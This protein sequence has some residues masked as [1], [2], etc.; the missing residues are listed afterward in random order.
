[1]SRPLR[2]LQ[3]ST[4]YPP[5]CFGGDGIYLQ[6]LARALA[7]Q[8]HRVDVVHCV[9]SYQMLQTVQPGIE[10]YKHPNLTVHSLQSRYG[11][12]SPLLSHQTGRPYLKERAIGEI[13]RSTQ[14]DVIHFHNISLLGPEVLALGREVE[15]VK[16]YTAHEYWLICPTH[17]LWKFNREPCE[18]ADCIRC[19][20]MAKRPPQL[21][22][23]TGMLAR[24]AREVDAFLAPSRFSAE[25]HRARGFEPPMQH[26][27]LFVERADADWQNPAPRPHERP[28]FL[29]VGR[30]ETIK[31]V[32]P[33]IEAWNKGA[34]TDLLIAGS[35]TEEA[36]LRILA[37]ANPRISFLGHVQPGALGSLYVNS[38]ACIVPSLCYEVF[39]NVVLESFARK[40]PII[41]HDH[42]AMSEMVRESGGGLLYTNEAELLSAVT[43]LSQSSM[44]RSELSEKA[45]RA[46][47][48][49]WSP[50]AHL[51]NYFEL[52]R[53]LAERKFG[54]IPWELAEGSSSPAE[55][56]EK[57]SSISRVATISRS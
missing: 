14:P 2:F 8:G 23:Y 26:F 16:L 33:L 34:Q 36:E 3:L 29:F 45:Y 42:G 6:R 28:Y 54:R 13:I 18:K 11:F 51:K 35:G 41:A 38:I 43:Q 47:D 7:E 48:A 12:V 4:F 37:G 1:M 19:T 56:S 17:V 25:I 52:L 57:Q 30:L 53:N 22:R 50:E 44:L 24:C 49:L 55:I 31:G 40:T 20:L 32:R 5:E 27:P 39:P 15:A 46:F 21:W 9:D 10:Q